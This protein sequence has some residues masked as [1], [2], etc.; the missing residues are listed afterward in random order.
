MKSGQKLILNA[1]YSEI[2]IRINPNQIFNPYQFELRLIQSEFSIRI[3]PISDSFKLILIE[4][5][6]WINPSSECR[7]GSDQLRSIRIN[8][9]GWIELIWVDFVSFLIKRDTTFL[10]NLNESELGLIQ[11]KFSIRINPNESEVGIIRIKNSVWVH[12]DWI[13]LIWIDFLLLFIK[14]DTKPFSKWFG[15]RS[16]NG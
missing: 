10:F 8:A 15:K 3:I 2:W 1:I 12:S 7:L 9:S 16:R 4:N 5:S 11:N 13:G 14:R 6:V